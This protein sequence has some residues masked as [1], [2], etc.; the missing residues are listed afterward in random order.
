[1]KYLK[2][3]EVWNYVRFKKND[4]EGVAKMEKGSEKESLMVDYFLDNDW[5]F[6]SID[7]SEYD[8]ESD[9]ELDI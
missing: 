2:I 1:M 3:Y 9:D 8:Q 5:E 7:K 6:D 4:A